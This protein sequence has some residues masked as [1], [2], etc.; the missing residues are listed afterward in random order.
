MALE[1]EVLAAGVDGASAVMGFGAIH[2]GPDAGDEVSAARIAIAWD[3]AVG[4]VAASGGVPLQF[5]GAPGGDATDFGV[6]SAITDGTFRGTVGL[7][8]D[9]AF[10]AAGEYNVTGVTLTGTDQT[11]P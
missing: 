11:P 8:G 5:T 1:D 3:P 4:V 2:D 6:W 9:Q 10:N 7:T